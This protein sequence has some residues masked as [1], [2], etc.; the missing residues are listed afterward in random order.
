MH[1]LLI[2]QTRNYYVTLPGMQ[3]R[4]QAKA[5]E[6]RM[7]MKLLE[8]P[9]ASSGELIL[10]WFEAVPRSPGGG[11]A[12]IPLKGLQGSEGSLWSLEGI[13][14]FWPRLGR[15][16]FGHLDPWALG[17]PIL[18]LSGWR[19]R[20]TAPPHTPLPRWHLWRHRRGPGC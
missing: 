13:S 20:G 1:P 14:I 15:G 8:A 5:E 12:G 18:G 10:R 2:K 16:S 7:G 3:G 11:Q 19:E 6:P 9:L 4:R 17:V